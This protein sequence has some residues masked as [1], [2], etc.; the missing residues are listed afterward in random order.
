MTQAME[1]YNWIAEKPKRQRN[2]PLFDKTVDKIMALEKKGSDP[3]SKD[4]R[5]KLMQSLY[6]DCL[7]AYPLGD[8]DPGLL[9]WVVEAVYY[10][11]N[12]P[13]VP[14]GKMVEF[15]DV[16]W[17]HLWRV[18]DYFLKYDKNMPNSLKM[19][20]LDIETR[21]VSMELWRQ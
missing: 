18:T 7:A 17:Y 2:S 21:I 19:H 9:C 12:L 6:E 3:K 10:I 5:K 13:G 4:N 8:E 11:L 15:A 1:M 20:I 14:M 16:E